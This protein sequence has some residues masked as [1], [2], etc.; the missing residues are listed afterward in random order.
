MEPFQLNST[1]KS[2]VFDVISI[3]PSLN[4]TEMKFFLTKNYLIIALK[5]TY[6]VKYNLELRSRR[7]YVFKLEEIDETLQRKG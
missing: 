7:Q 3:Y 1:I 6:I 2:T 5:I 4:A